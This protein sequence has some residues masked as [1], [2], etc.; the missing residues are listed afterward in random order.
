MGVLEKIIS[1]KLREVAQRKIEMPLSALEKVNHFHR[2][3]FS[4]RQ[5][6]LNKKGNAVI[7]EFKRKSPSKPTI[8]LHAEVVSV[9]MGYVQAGATAISVLTDEK[10]F[11]GS[12]HDLQRVREQVPV[13]L[14]RKDF[15][16]DEYQLVEAKACGADVILLIAAALP[17]DMVRKL[18]AKAHQL[19][20]EVLLEIHNE[21][22]W[23]ANADAGAEVIGV[24]NRN[25]RTMEV[26]ILTSLNMATIFPSDAVRITE[27][28]IRS[29]DEA[30][31]LA[32]AGYDGFL[33]GEY[34]MAQDNPVQ[35]AG[36]FIAALDRL[37]DVVKN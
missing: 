32:K 36:D 18:T 35:A 4:L 30:L 10:Y 28:G 19:G 1:D 7:A 27:S 31:Q 9:C 37:Q 13:P 5:A 24:N 26:D 15:I 23:K 2:D 33:I 6:I 21:E 22:E 25:L 34:F 3:T 14:L 11:G 20:L 8:N 17:P 29:T 12:L 16:V